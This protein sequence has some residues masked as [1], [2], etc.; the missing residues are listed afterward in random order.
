MSRQPRYSLLSA[1]ALTWINSIPFVVERA[2]ATTMTATFWLEKIRSTVTGQEV[3][4]LQYSQVIN[5]DF[6]QNSPDP[7]TG[8]I[9]W[10]HITVNTLVKQ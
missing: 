1:T 5:L 2:N 4:Q 7:S 8:L 10:P 6:H 9:G 3:D